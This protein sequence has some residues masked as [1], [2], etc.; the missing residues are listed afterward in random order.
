MVERY[1]L[2]LCTECTGSFA[3]CLH[4]LCFSPYSHKGTELLWMLIYGFKHKHLCAG[5]EVTSRFPTIRLNGSKDGKEWLQ[6]FSTCAWFGMITNH[7]RPS[8]ITMLNRAGRM[9]L[10]TSQVRSSGL[11][12][13]CCLV[14]SH[15]GYLSQVYN[16]MKRNIWSFSIT[17][18]PFTSYSNCKLLCYQGNVWHVCITFQRALFSVPQWK[19]KPHGLDW[20]G[21][22]LLSNG[23]GLARRWPLSVM[24]LFSLSRQ[25]KLRV[26]LGDLLW[27]KLMSWRTEALVDLNR[28]GG[29]GDVCSSRSR[30]TETD[31]LPDE[32]S[33]CLLS[34]LYSLC[35]KL[36]NP[37][38]TGSDSMDLFVAEQV[39]RSAALFIL[40]SWMSLHLSE[41]TGLSDSIKRLF[42]KSLWSE[43]RTKAAKVF[44]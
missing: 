9:H 36:D 39:A 22:E 37:N 2:I 38:N 15:V 43:E 11:V 18:L 42:W 16:K 28:R 7:S 31:W 5:F 1:I 3:Q 8:W 14:I 33:F 19:K 17:K 40:F 34:V 25:W 20:L 35:S 21:L 12:T 27:H 13:C 26:V 23:N 44:E 6:L 10:V 29:A 41:N 32:S 24:T 4:P 30:D